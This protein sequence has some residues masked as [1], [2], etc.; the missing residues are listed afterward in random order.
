MKMVPNIALRNIDIRTLKLINLLLLIAFLF[1]LEYVYKHFIV[2]HYH[3][4]GFNYDF[5][6]FKY[7]E[8][9]WILAVSLLLGYFIP[10]Q[11][12]FLYFITHVAIALLLIPNLIIYE[13]SNDI[14]VIPYLCLFFVFVLF[15]AGQVKYEFRYS[16]FIIPGRYRLFVLGIVV[17]ILLLPYVHIFG[18]DLHW[19]VLILED[20]YKVRDFFN[21]A[22]TTLTDYTYSPL[23]K[24]LIPVLLIFSLR[25][26]RYLLVA[27]SLLAMIYLYLTGA[28][29]V[30]L[31]GLFLL[32]FIYLFRNFYIQ[33][34]AL[35]C[36]L[37]ATL[38]IGHITYILF[39][40]SE[41]GNL[42]TRRFLLFPAL[43]N[44]FY[45]EFFQNNHIH[46]SHSVLEPFIDYPYELNPSYKICEVFKNNPTESCN[47]GFISSGYM[48]FGVPGV[49]GNIVFLGIMFR[50]LND[51][52]IHPVF[53]GVFIIMFYTLMSSELM[54]AL[55][56]H[57]I[58]LLMVIA[59]FLL[60]RTQ[61]ELE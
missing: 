27:F 19:K 48:N 43:Y 20:I 53:A 58:I 16:R 35:L 21:E 50:Y 34:T 11:K 28:H 22:S 26:K 7:F 18:F 47:N 36:L 10:N 38:A 4:F 51:L 55:L 3:D 13:F 54:T 25:K 49:I 40:F 39:D 57:G 41:I 32:L 31:L 33:V 24:I 23:A 6:L 15:L 2:V 30:H 45:F 37:I 9:K 5:H 12:N 56:T 60:N 14:R 61:N 52:K 17:F 1:I 44:E 42:F 8:T 46:L 29:K 59:Y